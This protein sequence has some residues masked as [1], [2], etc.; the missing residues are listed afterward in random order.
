MSAATLF[1]R[2]R[3]QVSRIFVRSNPV[4][5]WFARQ[6]DLLLYT[7]RGLQE[8]DTFVRSAA[9]TFYTLTSLV[10][11]AAVIFAVVKGFGRT[12]SLLENLYGL[13]P[14][15]PEI[16]DHLVA[17]AENALART[18]G[19]VM[20]AIALVLLFVSVASVCRSIENAFNNIW[21]VKNERGILRQLPAYIA[22][23][24]VMPLLWIVMSALGGYAR[25]LFG[26][27]DGW[28]ALLLTRMTSM[29][30]A[31]GMFA[32]FYYVVPNTEVRLTSALKAGIVAGT[33]F[34]LFQWGY[35]YLQRLM[36]SY[37]VIYGSFAALPL[38]LLWLHTSWQ[39]LL[40]GGD[41]S[42]AYQNVSR[43]KEERASM[44]VSPDQRRKILLAAMTVVVRRFCH[45]GGTTSAEEIRERLDLPLRIVTDVLN[46]LVAAGLLVEV[47]DGEDDRRV[48]FSPARDIAGMTL[49]D[50]MERVERTGQAR[51][52]L[53]AVP[54]LRRVESHVERLLRDARASEGNVRLT[55]LLG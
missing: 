33:A 25:E 11:I 5:R 14:Q 48:A 16:V 44:H 23:V 52:D 30:I 39:I 12:D 1:D 43:Y 31:W 41:L 19:G 54:D 13:F 18:Q 17:F 55:D 49:C 34:L 4:G 26:F 36:T 20:A 42:F 7:W 47:R 32:L 8:H 3:E 27:D 50:V 21:E 37:N 15:S 2:F 29:A 51:F 10:P 45:P 40:G 22:I 9:L 6:S 24:V 35:F 38:L 28:G 53:T 46:Q